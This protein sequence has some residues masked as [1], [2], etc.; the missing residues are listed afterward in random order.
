MTKSVSTLGIFWR[1]SGRLRRTLGSRSAGKRANC[2]SGTPFSRTPRRQNGH[3]AREV[4]QFLRNHNFQ[5]AQV[6]VA[7][8][9]VRSTGVAPNVILESKLLDLTRILRPLLGAIFSRKTT[10]SR[11]TCG[12][13]GPPRHDAKRN[14]FG[15]NG[16]LPPPARSFQAPGGGVGEGQV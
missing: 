9:A 11:G 12:K 4:S 3:I 1:P 7:Q 13:N 2:A 8:K 6:V 14:T 16:P 10:I 5:C 15:T